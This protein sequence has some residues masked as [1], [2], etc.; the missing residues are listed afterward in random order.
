MATRILLDARSVDIWPYGVGRYAREIATRLP[1]SRPDWEWIILRY[2][3]APASCSGNVTTLW[4]PVDFSDYPSQQL[5]LDEVIATT[6]PGLVHSLWFPSVENFDGPAL[7]TIQD[8]ISMKGHPEFMTEVGIIQNYWQRRTCGAAA[9]VIVPSFYTLRDVSAIY[10]YPVDQLTV[11]PHAPSNAFLHVTKSDI[12]TCRAKYR[13]PDAYI[14]SSA[15]IPTSYKNSAVVPQALD[16]LRSQGVN[17]PPLVSTGSR[18]PEMRANWIQ[19]LLLDDADLAAVMAGAT[20][21][22]YPSKA[23]GFGFPLLEAMACGVPAITSN[24]AS[25]P[26]IGGEAVVYFNPDSV[27]ELAASISALLSGEKTRKRLSEA[28]RRRAAQFTWER[29]V[30]ATLALY[31]RL[32]ASPERGPKTRIDWRHA[33]GSGFSVCAAARDS[34]EDLVKLEQRYQLNPGDPDALRDLGKAYKKLTRWSDARRVF[35]KMLEVANVGKMEEHSRSALFHLGECC[36]NEGDLDE[37]ETRLKEC[38]VVCPSHQA[39]P[40]LLQ[41]VKLARNR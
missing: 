7:I 29:T 25:L 41:K 2:G 20:M 21:L 27:H 38:L 35:V 11:I 40:L 4:Q 5:V 10:G 28:G 30:S 6:Q 13:L 33:G 24:A 37:A 16:I 9:H 1:V 34:G 19:L 12:R 18:N 14:Y 8:A 31:D 39:A 15:H 26:E 3:K 23:E 22:V 17:V 32:L 36:L